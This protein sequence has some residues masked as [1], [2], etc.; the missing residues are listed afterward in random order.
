[1]NIIKLEAL[2]E[3]LLVDENEVIE[4][5]GITQSRISTIGT[6]IVKLMKSKIIFDVVHSDFPISTDEMLGRE[7]LRQEKIEISFWHNKK[8]TYSNATKPIPFIDNESRAALGNTTDYKG[9]TLGIIQVRDWT[10]RVIP[11]AVINSEIKEG[12]LSV[13]K[14][15][16]AC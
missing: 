15:T 10:R 2:D 11:I 12:Y 5:T 14:T 1:M 4:I 3:D 13:I 7:Y 16:K 9:P 8:V 6:V